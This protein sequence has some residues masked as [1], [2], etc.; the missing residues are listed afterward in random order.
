MTRWLDQYKHITPI[1]WGDRKIGPGH[2]PLV[3]AEIAANHQGDFALAKKMIQVAAA[4]GADAVKFQLHIVEDEMLKVLPPWE[5]LDEPLWDLLVR[6]HF[7]PEQHKELMRYCEMQGVKYLCTPFSRAAADI[8]EDLGVDMFK[9]GSGEL[10]NTPL[11]R[12]IAQK[13]TPAIVSTG[14][15]TWDEIQETVEVWKKAGTPFMLTHCISAYPAPYAST[16]LGVIP[17]MMD[18]FRV[19]VG[20]SDH[21]LGPYTCFGAV[22]LGA[23]LFEKHFTLDRWMKGPDHEA[24]IEPA[25]LQELSKGSAAIFE[26]L[27]ME[28]K[29]FEEER[30]VRAWAHHS[31]VT[32]RPIKKGEKLSAQNVWVK[33]PGPGKDGIPAKS[34][35]AV[36]G[37]VAKRALPRDQQVLWA[38]V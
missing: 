28:R 30:Q 22:P 21:S 5:N 10:T 27:G 4:N 1:R 29:V 25:G 33:R 34:Y 23:A 19:P 17:Q 8:L 3:I 11:Q 24:S 9:T 38:D 2:R 32:T 37:K 20:L 6:T 36:L 13:G 18:R 31:V 12:H 35:D 14:M 7:T 26:A 15:S 16:N